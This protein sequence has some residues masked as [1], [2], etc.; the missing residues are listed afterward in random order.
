MVVYIHLPGLKAYQ[1]QK[2]Y[3]TNNSY[4]YHFKTVS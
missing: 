4:R 3:H 1:Q 2:R